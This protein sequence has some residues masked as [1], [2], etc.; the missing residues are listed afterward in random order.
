LKKGEFFEL[1]FEATCQ[2][3]IIILKE[4]AEYELERPILIRE[5]QGILR[6]FGLDY[7]TSWANTC[8]CF[9][10]NSG[11]TYSAGE[12]ADD[13]LVHRALLAKLAKS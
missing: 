10:P 2:A 4:V 7:R 8:S 9:Q 13:E 12:N 5:A 3:H 1:H 6:C 11:N